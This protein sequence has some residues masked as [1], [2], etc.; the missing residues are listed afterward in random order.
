M[1]TDAPRSLAGL[2]VL[3]VDDDERMRDMLTMML[4]HAGARVR[5]CAKGPEALDALR[6]AV[7]DVVVMDIN[8]PGPSGLSVIRTIRHL[9]DPAARA[10]PALALSGYGDQ[11]EHTPISDAGFNDFLGKPFR[12]DRFV[13]AV[14]QVARRVA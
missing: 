9:D 10:V 13:G 1:M 2:Y 7:P 14:E 11:L 5:A 6:L 8:L 4:E 3:L 12:M